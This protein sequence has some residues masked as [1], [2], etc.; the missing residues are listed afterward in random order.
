MDTFS[1]SDP[2]VILLVMDENNRWLEYGRTE[3]IK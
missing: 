3:M 1:K 2:M